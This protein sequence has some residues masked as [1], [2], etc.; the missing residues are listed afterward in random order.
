MLSFHFRVL[1]IVGPVQVVGVVGPVVGLSVAEFKAGPLGW[2][3]CPVRFG[4]TPGE[5]PSVRTGRDRHSSA[6]AGNIK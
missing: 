6:E 1:E 2:R 5:Q 3:C 4:A